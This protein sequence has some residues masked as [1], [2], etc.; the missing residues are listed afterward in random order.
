MEEKKQDTNKSSSPRG[1]IAIGI[2]VII[3]LIVGLIFMIQLAI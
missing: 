3:F 1:L 2:G